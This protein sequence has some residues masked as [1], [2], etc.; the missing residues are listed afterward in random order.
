MRTYQEIVRDA[1]AIEPMGPFKTWLWMLFKEFE[2]MKP[3]P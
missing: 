2:P 3:M 1:D